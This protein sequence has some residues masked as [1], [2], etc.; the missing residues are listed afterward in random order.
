METSATVPIQGGVGGAAASPGGKKTAVTKGVATSGSSPSKHLKS[1]GGVDGDE[2]VV[3]ELTVRQLPDKPAFDKEREFPGVAKQRLARKDKHMKA[4]DDYAKL[5]DDVSE[6]LEQELLTAS[7]VMREKLEEV[8]AER[9]EK[10]RQ[11]RDDAFLIVRSEDDLIDELGSLKGLLSR[12]S[13]IV[14]NFAAQLD[15][16]EA[17]RADVLTKEMKKLVDLLIAIGKRCLLST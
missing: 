11:Y 3:D 4:L 15:G 5:L 2:R 9:E 17:K 16:L 14:E 6:S 13:Q 7:R 12:R 1:S 8:D 10:H